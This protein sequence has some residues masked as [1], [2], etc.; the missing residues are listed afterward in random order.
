MHDPSKP[1]IY[2]YN[3]VYSAYVKDEL[4][5]NPVLFGAVH[6]E[7][8]NEIVNG[9]RVQN[10][11]DTNF[12]VNPNFNV[13]NCASGYT[14]SVYNDCW[15]AYNAFISLATIPYNTATT[16]GRIPWTNLGPMVWPST[17]YTKPDGSKASDG[18][19][20][21]TFFASNDGYL[22]VYYLDNSI[23]GGG[24]YGIKVARALISDLPTKGQFAFYSYV[25]GSFNQPTLPTG[26]SN[27]SIA[28]FYSTKGPQT[29]SL[30]DTSV[31]TPISFAVAA[32]AGTSDYIG[33]LQYLD[34]NN[35]LRVA[36]TT[37]SDLVHWSSPITVEQSPSWGS[38]T[39]DFPLFIDS[40]GWTNT[41]VD[42]S[43]FYIE[44]TDVSGGVHLLHLS[45]K[46][47]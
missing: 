36:L 47:Q 21:P 9:T 25:N 39:L 2:N 37:S 33:V 26:F 27:A 38:G 23:A 8:K 20:V 11:V 34:S 18:V 30:F 10:T 24:L 6:G 7:D 35:I 46:V 41:H 13:A 15:D 17:G 4:G 5:S 40:T 19:R 28:S 16:W 32:V 44:G 12:S 1:W 45:V 43:N 14:G 42:P 31:T 22:Y 3:G 29:L